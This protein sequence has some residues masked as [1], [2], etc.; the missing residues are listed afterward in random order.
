MP[1]SSSAG[2]R[3]ATARSS[4]GSASTWTIR[5][6]RR[7]SS[8]ASESLTTRPRHRSAGSAKHGAS[9][10]IFVDFGHTPWVS[11]SM[12]LFDLAH[13]TDRV[14]PGSRPPRCAA[15]AHGKRFLSRADRARRTCDGAGACHA[16]A[17]RASLPGAVDVAVLLGMRSGAPGLP[18]ARGRAA[19]RDMRARGRRPAGMPWSTWTRW[20]ASTRAR[21]R[22]PP[23]QRRARPC[24]HRDPGPR[25]TP[26]IFGFGFGVGARED[27]GRRAACDACPPGRRCSW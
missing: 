24:D 27:P 4:A 20:R 19:L 17:R 16:R 26:R 21:K 8:S 25:S 13:L 1:P 22:P 7:S 18:L 10:T 5:R 9:R 6:T 3:H 14:R 2:C 11:A 23:Q 12:S 15:R